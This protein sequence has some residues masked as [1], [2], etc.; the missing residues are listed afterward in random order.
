MATALVPLEYVDG[1]CFSKKLIYMSVQDL[2]PKNRNGN[3]DVRAHCAKDMDLIYCSFIL[4]TIIIN[5]VDGIMLH[6][7]NVLSGYLFLL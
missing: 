3:G 1:N 7:L 2:L 6:L 5:C 4:G